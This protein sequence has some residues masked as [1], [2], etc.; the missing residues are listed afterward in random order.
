MAVNSKQ[1]GSQENR[2]DE[3]STAANFQFN[4]HQLKGGGGG[5]RKGGG[6]R[7]GEDGTED[8]GG[9]IL[10]ANADGTVQSHP[11]LKRDPQITIRS[12]FLPLGSG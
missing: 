9:G 12:G 10:I 2:L 1:P 11:A 8:S 3:K 7:S 4:L 6:R 5:R